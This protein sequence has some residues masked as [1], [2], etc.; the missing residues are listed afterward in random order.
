MLTKEQV[1]QILFHPENHEWTTQGLG[2]LRTY[3]DPSGI[4]RLHIWD[5][6][7]VNPQ[8]SRIHDHPWS[9]ESRV[10]A[11]GLV[12]QR[13]YRSE[14]PNSMEYQLVQI[15]CGAGGGPV[16]GIETVHLLMVQEEELN[17]GDVYAQHWTEL[18]DSAAEDG[19]VTI[20]KRDFKTDTEH[21]TVCW[22]KGPWGSA[23]PRR[24]EPE[25]VRYVTQ[26]ALERWF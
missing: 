21:A 12:N 25:E 1:R 23:E 26:T 13:Y 20:I 16:S 10:I 18:H 2:M 15:K 7:Q 11:G 24:A 14:H 17:A 9:F 22:E 5:S 19:T 6:S 4:Y 8:A 3:L